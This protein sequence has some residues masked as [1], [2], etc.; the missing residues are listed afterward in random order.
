MTEQ[1]IFKYSSFR[2]FMA[3]AQPVSKLVD[4]TEDSFTRFFGIAGT[5]YCPITIPVNFI[6]KDLSVEF[7]DARG[8]SLIDSGVISAK[9]NKERAMFYHVVDKPSKTIAI[10][11]NIN[12][13]SKDVLTSQSTSYARGVCVKFTIM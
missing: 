2:E 6:G 10:S 9:N 5:D 4:Q 7:Y 1:D 12:G 8:K 13:R 11:A 3:E